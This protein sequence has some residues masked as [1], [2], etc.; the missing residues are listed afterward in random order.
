MA[1]R[2]ALLGA[3]LLA[4]HLGACKSGD[5]ALGN[6]TPSVD[7]LRACLDRPVDLPRPPAGNLPCELIPPGLSL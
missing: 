5:S 2:I 3:L 1:R 7:T 4:A 6:P